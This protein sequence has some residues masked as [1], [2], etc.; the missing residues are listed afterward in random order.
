MGPPDSSGHRRDSATRPAA[1][2]HR[3]AR[4]AFMPARQ[5]VSPRDQV[6]TNNA[7]DQ[8]ARRLQQGFPNEAALSET[9]HLSLATAAADS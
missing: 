2:C 1:V 6:S 8:T 4:P 3:F 7:R 5:A 9:G